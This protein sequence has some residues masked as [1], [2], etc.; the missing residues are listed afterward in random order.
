[1][2]ALVS[3]VFVFHISTLK[4]FDLSSSGNPQVWVK[5][6]MATRGYNSA[7]F[8]SLPSNNAT[9]SREL[10]LALMWITAKE[11]ALASLT[12]ECV[13]QSPLCQE[14][15]DAPKKQVR[16]NSG[17]AIFN[18]IVVFDLMVASLLTF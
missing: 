10:L 3:I 11:N 13:R 8:Y 6:Q 7:E 4:D 1:M 18:N 14:Y 2:H 12:Q 15:S 5:L 16:R 9:G 17:C